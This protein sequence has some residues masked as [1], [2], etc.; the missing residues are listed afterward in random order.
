MSSKVLPNGERWDIV[1]TRYPK[2]AGPS[3]DSGTVAEWLQIRDGPEISPTYWGYF[4]PGS[5]PDPAYSGV[6]G[7]VTTMVPAMMSARSWSIS[8]DSS[9]ETLPARSWNGEMSTP[10]FSSVPM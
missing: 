6:L 5:G 10:P 3:R 8:A 7:L 2:L 4:A 1:P 9:A